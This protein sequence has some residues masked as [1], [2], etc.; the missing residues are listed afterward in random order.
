MGHFDMVEIG[1]DE[2]A[3]NE[4]V[5]SGWPPGSL[6]LSMLINRFYFGET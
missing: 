2:E 5:N 6:F 1:F 4:M 3:L